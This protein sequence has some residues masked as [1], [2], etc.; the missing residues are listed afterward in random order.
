MHTSP[1]TPKHGASEMVDMGLGDFSD[2]GGTSD[3]VNLLSEP[4]ACAAPSSRGKGKSAAS[5]ARGRGKGD[6]ASAG[7]NKKG[8]T[9]CIACAKNLPVTM[10]SSHC[11]YC[12]A[13]EARIKRLRRLAKAQNKTEWFAQ[14]L[15]SPERLQRMVKYYSDRCP[16]KPD[17]SYPPL[18][19]TVFGE[20]EQASTYSDSFQDGIMMHQEG[21]VKFWQGEEGGG[22]SY[23]EAIE[24]WEDSASKARVG[25][26]PTDEDAPPP[27]G[28]R[29]ASGSRPTSTRRSVRNM[30]RGSLSARRR[31]R[32]S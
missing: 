13:D 25:K 2:D 28:R 10:F 21:A 22:L 32:R 8:K 16:P 1:S 27:P 29:S 3:G 15:K 6:Q 14:V 9:W 20:Y 17:G 4:A 12:Q 5:G 18:I 23:L 7:S 11:P 31:S 30:R 19:L 24:K 26:I